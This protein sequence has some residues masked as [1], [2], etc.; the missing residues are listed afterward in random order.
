MDCQSLV[1]YVQWRVE[2]WHAKNLPFSGRIELVR[3]VILAIARF[4]LQA[5]LLPTATMR[6]IERTCA[7]FVWR[8][9][10]HAIGWDNLCRPRKEGRVSL[11][12]LY[13]LRDIA[14]LKLTWMM[15]TKR[16]LWVQ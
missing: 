15:L 4:W 3:A 8:E 1:E 14:D 7:T 9:G 5:T 6:R 11:Q 10:I 16:S 12:P 13:L 2:G